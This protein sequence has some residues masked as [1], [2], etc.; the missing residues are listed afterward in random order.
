MET[1]TPAVELL[2][3]RLV[4]ALHAA[5]PACGG[6]VGAHDNRCAACDA[7]L[8]DEDDMLGWGGEPANLI[9]LRT[10][11]DAWLNGESEVDPALAVTEE[12]F[13]GARQASQVLGALLTPARTENLLAEG[14]D[15][16]ISAADN[17]ARLVHLLMAYRSSLVAEDP[18]AARGDLR[19]VATQMRIMDRLQSRVD[20]EIAALCQ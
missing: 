14:F 5:C 19:A 13:R 10:T 6:P 18:D 2:S 17:F 1:P 11:F 8:T 20:D 12:L 15:S 9:R 16:I 4:E 3:R 7:V